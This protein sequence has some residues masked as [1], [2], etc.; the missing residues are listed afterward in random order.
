MVFLAHF[1]QTRRE[2]SHLVQIKAVL[3]PSPDMAM[4]FHLQLDMNPPTCPF[5]TMYSHRTHLPGTLP[6]RNSLKLK[7]HATITQLG[8]SHSFCSC[9]TCLPRTLPQVTIVK[10]KVHIIHSS[11]THVHTYGSTVYSR[12]STLSFGMLTFRST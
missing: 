1:V 10:M 2:M 4:L 3:Q 9:I 12:I 11:F 7:S 6:K 8:V 5:S